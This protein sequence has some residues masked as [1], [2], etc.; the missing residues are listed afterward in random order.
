MKYEAEKL[1]EQYENSLW[2]RYLVILL[3]IWMIAT[4]LSFSYQSNLMFWND[5]IVGILLCIFGFLALDRNKN[6]ASWV[7]CFLGIWLQAS[8][9][10]L[11][12][13][14]PITYLNDTIIGVLA[15]AF[16]ILIPRVPEE[17]NLGDPDIPEG[18]SYNPS[19]WLQRMPVIFFGFIGWLI[20]RYMGAYQLGYLNHIID[21]VFPNGT[22]SVITSPLSKSFPISDAGLGALAY[23][24]EF[25]MGFKGSDR[26]WFTMPWFVILFAIL[27][28]PVG[29]VSIALIISQ[30]LIVGAWCFW[31][32][33]TAICMLIMLALTVD[34]AVAVLQYLTN[35]KKYGSSFMEVFWK[36]GVSSGSQYDFRSPPI[37]ENISKTFPAMTWGF[38]VPWNLMLSAL[39][40]AWMIYSVHMFSTNLAA[41]NDYILGA[42][43][44]TFSIIAMAEVTRSVRFINLLIG[45]WIFISTWVLPGFSEFGEINQ[46]IMGIILFH[47]SIPRGK[48]L[49]RYG[50]WTKYIK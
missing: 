50:S 34:E 40:G 33:L 35:Y 41:S 39:L 45:L 16:S 9:L 2:S 5:C 15:I 10:F 47:L 42:L 38:N 22:L 31:C 26:R 19:S 44:I 13:P 29:F 4:S 49:E 6:W 12:A 32:I 23:T 11:W 37:A 48:I 3:G 17:K 18:W 25:L 36:G 28:I 46:A 8:P 21:P 30:P 24:L 14:D 27:V 7:C 43:I 1:K 20:A